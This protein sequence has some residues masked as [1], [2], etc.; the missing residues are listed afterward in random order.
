MKC[1]FRFTT[2]AQRQL[3]SIGQVEAMRI[4]SALTALGDDPFAEGL[5][6]K[7]PTGH[8]GLHR[9]RV[10]AHRVVYEVRGGETVVLVV[11]VGNRR[12][13]CRRL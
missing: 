7:R 8:D 12:D 3:R 10:G 1:A 5:G 11:N 2:H 9:L 13:V 6:V 4:L